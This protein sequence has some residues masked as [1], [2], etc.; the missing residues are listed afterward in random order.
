[1]GLINVTFILFSFS[2]LLQIILF[3]YLNRK[4]RLFMD[5]E[6]NSVTT[7]KSISI[8]K[9]NN[10][11]GVILLVDLSISP[12]LYSDCKNILD[13]LSKEN[14]KYYVLNY[15]DLLNS[16]RRLLIELNV[17]R[18]PCLIVMENGLNVSRLSLPLQSVEKVLYEVKLI[19]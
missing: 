9:L 18:L 16:D 11:T 7:V 2:V 4:L 5:F 10:F 12:D 14:C 1:M 6:K 3:I 15:S 13:Y 8:K 19:S 17:D